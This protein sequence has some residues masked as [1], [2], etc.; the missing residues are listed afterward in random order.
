VVCFQHGR[1]TGVDDA[2]ALSL[3]VLPSLEGGARLSQR[4]PGGVGRGWPSTSS[5]ARPLTAVPDCA[6]WRWPPRA[7]V[8]S[9]TSVRR[10]AAA[11]QALHELR[12]RDV[13]HE[14]RHVARLV[15][16][17]TAQLGEPPPQIHPLVVQFVVRG[18]R[19]ELLA[20]GAL[21]PRPRADV[22]ALE[23]DRPQLVT[24]P[25]AGRSELSL[26]SHVLPEAGPLVR[27]DRARYA[28]RR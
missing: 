3:R 10:S 4:R 17:A 1:G 19:L 26:P 11:P 16:L 14:A 2:A 27:R 7:S 12:A 22:I 20:L 23:R 9:R 28:D 13:I 8:G 18:A 24:A 25:I 21:L 5:C 15:L 6:R